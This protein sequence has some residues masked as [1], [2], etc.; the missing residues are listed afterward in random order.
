MRLLFACYTTTT[1]TILNLATQEQANAFSLTSTSTHTPSTSTSIRTSTTSKP[2]SS[3]HTQ[4]FQ[5]ALPQ[6]DKFY[7]GYDDFI[8]N[9]QQDLEND[10]FDIYNDDNKYERQRQ[11]QRQQR[12]QTSPANNDDDDDDDSR[13]YSPSYSQSQSPQ[14]RIKK[15]KP[16]YRRDPTDDMSKTVNEKEVTRL[17]SL[18][19]KAQH[20]R[21]YVVADDIRDELNTAHGVYVWD[22]DGLWSASPVA[23]SR[24]YNNYAAA[25][26]ASSDGIGVSD[27]RSRDRDRD[28][29]NGRQ[30]PRKPRQFGRHGHDYTQIG[31]EIDA[32]SCPLPIHEIHSL[33]ARRL[34]HK[35]SRQYDKADEI[36]STLYDNGV[37]IHDKL[38]QWRADGGIFADMEA[39]AAGK[40]FQINEYSGAIDD[41]GTGALAVIEQ[42]VTTRDDARAGFDYA[43][44]DRL[45]AV[46]WDTYRVAVDDKSR[47]YSLGGDFGPD[48]T[49]RWTDDGPINPRKG[50]DPALSRDWRVFGG[51]Y[52]KSL[53]SESVKEE[54]EEE[55]YNLIHDRLEAKRV[56]D[57][58]VADLIRDHLYQIYHISVDDQ[59]RQW[60]VGGEF[61]DSATES[62]RKN[63]PT[64]PDGK[65]TSSYIRR[66]NRRGGTGHLTD[67]E[68]SMVEAMIQRRSEEMSRFNRQA[69]ESIRNG[70]KN[71]YYVIIDDINDEW[72][73]RGNDFILSPAWEGHLP[74]A[75]E[76]SREEIEKLIR[77]RSQ[78]KGEK[79]FT[80]ADEIRADLFETYN[81]K[82]DDRIKEWSVMDG[83]RR[84]S[85][86]S[87][88]DESESSLSKLTV[89]E[90]KDKLRASDLPVTGR[91]ADLIQRILNIE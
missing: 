82:M 61:D 35:L 21:N 77:E 37:K 85:S 63:S 90:L 58:A 73:I 31:D 12:E 74:P 3:I 69:A 55:I 89:L 57:Y 91:K 48:G 15:Q 40:P 65:L 86:S 8:K 71:K 72:H 24:R 1:I 54:D 6:D 75:V 49:F 53:F 19:T 67:T 10:S 17:I 50:R 44:A 46:L 26:A 9:L 32:A 87:L 79:D 39:I 27:A 64:A 4:L 28:R 83:G 34:E 16:G 11:R 76:E 42:L 20:E 70:L 51:M 45:R 80:R 43:E 66:Y 78:A 81:V 56:K 84:K 23:P 52:T 68:V 29:D 47:S 41:I 60:S 36:Q 33:I 30:S 13:Q 18:R 25:S 2:H 7:D 88:V 14:R 38:K 5:N 22:K 59:L 62:L